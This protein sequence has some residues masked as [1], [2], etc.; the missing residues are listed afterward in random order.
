MENLLYYGD[1]L[2][3]MRR[4]IKDETV[5]LV[6]LDPPFNSNTNYN[7]LFAEKDGS[8]AASQIQAF[9]DTWTWNQESESVY[10]EIVM[11]GG[12]V[13][14]CLQAFRTFL[15]ECDML[16]YLVMMAPRLVELQRV[17]KVTA[18]IYLH[19]DPT[20]S[21]YLKMLMD[22]IYGP[23]NF[24]NEIIWR[25]TNSHNKTSKQYGPIH[26]SIL[27]YSKT[28]VFTFHPGVRPY[29][30]AYIEDRFKFHDSRGRYQLNYLT[31]PGI[32]HGESGLEWRGFNP[33]SAGRHWAIPASLR[34]Y[35]SGKETK[36]ISVLEE[37]LAQELI[38]FPKKKGGQPMYKQY[39]GAGVYYQDIWAYQPNTAGVLFENDECIDED[40]KY[41]EGEEEKLGYETQKPVG[42]LARI[43]ATSTNR[44]D[45]ILDPFCGC[46]TTIAAAQAL[47]RPWIGIDI[48]YPAIG[49]IKTRLKDA[50]GESITFKII[51]EPVSLP[52]AERL[53][54]SEPFQFQAWALGLV[55]ARVATSAKKGADKGIDGKII[56]QGDK[57][58]N[59]ETVIFS[60][61]AGHTNVAHVRDL[62]GVLDREKA[63]IGVLISMQ[64]S[65]SPMKTEAITAGFYESTTW[66]KKYPKIQLITIAELLAGIKKVEMPPIKQVGATFKKA[67]KVMK[68]GTEQGELL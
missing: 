25:R 2:D 10:G 66:G 62:K 31:G 59:F 9:T 16:A 43:I 1:N 51:G 61:K 6:Y 34:Q 63:A 4:H 3:V 52:D 18:S 12:K 20:A 39:V 47:S 44:G 46:G 57:P 29:T 41:L 42:L 5:D 15:G 30:K 60:V 26:D 58:G 54:Q 17:M 23:E 67:P 14:D 55:G 27:F 40:V 36:T 28:G 64:E 37:L 35:L 50:F 13:S 45:K 8:K 65:T 38:V 68:S 21:H 7:I 32:R 49:L 53:A 56:F 19:C 24:R 48:T 11:A 33:T 22:A